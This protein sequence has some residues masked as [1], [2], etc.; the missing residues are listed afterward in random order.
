MWEGYCPSFLKRMVSIKQHLKFFYSLVGSALWGFGFLVHIILVCFSI[1]ALFNTPDFSSNVIDQA[2]KTLLTLDVLELTFIND[3]AALDPGFI[4][5]KA[6]PSKI[7]QTKKF[8]S[9]LSASEITEVFLVL[10]KEKSSLLKRNSDYKVQLE[11]DKINNDIADIYNSTFDKECP[12]CHVW[13]SGY[14]LYGESFE[15][16]SLAFVTERLK[17]IS[18]IST[19]RIV[20]WTTIGKIAL[21]VL[22]LI[23]AMLVFYFWKSKNIGFLIWFENFLFSLSPMLLLLY[24]IGSTL[25]SI[26]NY[27][28]SGFPS[29]AG[30]YSYEF[31]IKIA[32]AGFIGLFVLTPVALKIRKYRKVKYFHQD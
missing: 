2:R 29:P 1:T 27:K 31:F 8:E 21:G 30:A 20:F 14:K 17:K 7:Y 18:K 6:A 11:I 15:D 10:I 3:E 12:E 5:D 28:D 4:E 26:D 9:K 24:L 19:K 32:L 22:I 16:N 25:S 13:V 23:L